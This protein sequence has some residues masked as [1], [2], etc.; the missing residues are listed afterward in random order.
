MGTRKTPVL[1]REG[2]LSDRGAPRTS[3]A[4]ADQDRVSLLG[5]ADPPFECS[6][7]EQRLVSPWKPILEQ[8]T[9]PASTE[10]ES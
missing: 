7:V 8:G 10:G 3:L 2:A 1:L 6:G 4:A 9:K 5:D